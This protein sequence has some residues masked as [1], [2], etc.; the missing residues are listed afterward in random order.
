M[1]NAESMY[2]VRSGLVQ[3]E[4]TVN[5]DRENIWPM[6]KHLWRKNKVNRVMKYTHKVYSNEYFG[7]VELLK[8]CKRLH[9]VIC[10]TN[11]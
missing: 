9:R 6:E 4:C 3:I 2:I 1:D 5:I 11:C 7:E 8:N 10:L